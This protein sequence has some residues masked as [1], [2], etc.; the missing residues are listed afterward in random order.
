MVLSNVIRMKVGTVI[1]FRQFEPVF[2]MRC[3]AHSATIQVV[4]YTKF[5]TVSLAF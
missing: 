5:H 4:K 3:Q 2:K 1:D